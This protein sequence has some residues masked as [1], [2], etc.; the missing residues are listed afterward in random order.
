M[1]ETTPMRVE[2]CWLDFMGNSPED[3]FSSLRSSGFGLIEEIHD[4]QV[5]QSNAFPNF[6]VEFLKV[7]NSKPQEPVSKLLGLSAD[8]VDNDRGKVC[9]WQRMDPFFRCMIY[10]LPDSTGR[11]LQLGD[12][13]TR[14]K[15]VLCNLFGR[16]AA[17]TFWET[18]AF[19]ACA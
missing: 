7:D 3:L 14:L 9:G 15:T 19:A 6:A 1:G 5:W 10:C 4:L 16:R 17:V 13:F 11:L 18:R 12:E 8:Q 2:V